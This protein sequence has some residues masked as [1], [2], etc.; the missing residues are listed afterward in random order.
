MTLYNRLLDLLCNISEWV[1]GIALVF[2]T[3]IFGWLVFGRYVLNATPT[4]VEQVSLLLII[5]IGFLGASV[6]VR[7]KTHLS[8]SFFRDY[9]PR[10]VK[11]LFELLSILVMGGF[12]AVMAVNSYNLAIFKWD[13]D[14]PL[15]NWPEGLR[16]IP[17]TLC[18]ILVLLY[19]ISHIIEWWQGVDAPALEDVVPPH[20]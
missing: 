18:G 9:S 10:P 5:L 6:G 8:V 7:Y 1:C 14:I 15:L 12:G 13:S 17:I 3:V 20:T 4:W 11:R 19:S 2:L 16:A